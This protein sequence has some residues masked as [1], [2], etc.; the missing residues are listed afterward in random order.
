MNIAERI[1]QVRKDAKL[2]Q[3]DFG[4]KL[5][6]SRSVINN[7]ELDR[8]KNGI[9]ENIIK[10]ICCVFNVNEEWLKNGKGSKYSLKIKTTLD[11]LA[12]DYNMSELEYTILS[13]YLALDLNQRKAVEN[14]IINLQNNLNI[15]QQNNDKE[16]TMKYVNAVFEEDEKVNG[17][18]S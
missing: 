16:E 2:S 17:K 13:H 15:K 3:S 10:L 4:E 5:G 14:F 1:K 8:N 18:S 12:E 6:V 9:Q 7:I 11:T